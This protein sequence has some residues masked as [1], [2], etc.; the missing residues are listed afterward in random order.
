MFTGLVQGVGQ[1]LHVERL[2]AGRAGGGVRITVD[3]AGV[4]GFAA[5]V[6]DSIAV[7]G[8]C[9]TVT[10]IDGGRFSCI[11]SGESLRVTVGL[12]RTGEVNVE[13]SLRV[14]DALGGH[15]VAG[16]VDGIGSVVEFAQDHE[17]WVLVVRAPFDLSGFI[18]QKGSIAVNGV[19][20][21]INRVTDA[22]AGSGMGCEFSMNIIPHTYAATALRLLRE[23]DR[24]NLE[25]DL[26][27]RYVQRRLTA[28]SR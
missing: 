16:H 8:A 18:A 10:E 7:N 2:D 12:D 26:I 4:P 22:H 15:W 14:G 24:V 25:V 20:L 19:S 21:T 1:I 6:G 13:S 11:V 3:A 9:L 23:G 5:A 17:S 27:A 28:P